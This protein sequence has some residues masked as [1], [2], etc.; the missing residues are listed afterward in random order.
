M[1]AL[2]LEAASAR[3]AAIFELLTGQPALKLVIISSQLLT[4]THS[5]VLRAVKVQI[6]PADIMQG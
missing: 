5:A 3:D 4:E 1:H 2:E 6:R